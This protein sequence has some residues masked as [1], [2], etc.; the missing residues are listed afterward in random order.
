M[1]HRY[2]PLAV[3]LS[4]SS[5]AIAAPRHVAP[6]DAQRSAQRHPRHP[7]PARERS[8]HGARHHGTHAP[9][10]TDAPPRSEPPTPPPTGRNP[11]IPIP[12]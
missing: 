5:A 4:L 1:I 11:L 8:H 7:R 9:P 3:V 6:D 2:L 12:F 10:A